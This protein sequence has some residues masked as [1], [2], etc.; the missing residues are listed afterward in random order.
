M[1]S[2]SQVEKTSFFEYLGLADMEKVHSQIL[3]WMLSENC[4]ALSSK[5]KVKLLQAITGSDKPFIIRNVLTEESDI[6]IYVE[7]ADAIVVIEN[8]IKSS[9]HSDQLLEYEA[10]VRSLNS[11]KSA[12]YVFLTLIEEKAKSGSWINCGYNKI[13]KVLE[14]CAL[15]TANFDTTIAIEYRV[16]L[17]K[18][19]SVVLHF[20]DHP[21]EYKNVFTF[22]HVKKSEKRKAK[23]E[24]YH[25][26]FISDNQ[27]ETILQKCYLAK[28][29]ENVALPESYQWDISETR[30]VALVNCYSSNLIGLNNKQFKTVFQFQRG[31]FKFAFTVN[32]DYNKSKKQ[33]LGSVVNILGDMSKNN[34]LGYTRHNLPQSNAWVS[35]SKV[36]K[37]KYYTLSFSE[38]TKMFRREFQNFLI[39]DS[40][41]RHA[42]SQISPGSA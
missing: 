31:A 32:S 23:F 35:I 25:Q 13:S 10:H 40:T 34:H 1:N 14:N 3:A 39:L 20:I 17:K 9:Q 24:T 29:M 21:V 41:L 5:E 30:G 4:I 38:F 26:K 18:L 6:D 8:K 42:I 27:L 36:P 37:A 12:F 19:I 22:G 33:E 16:F 15:S 2:I 7:C 28:I 11:Q